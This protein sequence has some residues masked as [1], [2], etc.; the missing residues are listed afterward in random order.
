MTRYP[1]ARLDPAAR[2]GLLLAGMGGPDGPE[3]VAPFLANLFRD[4][5]VLPLPA[6]LARALG[7]LLVRLRARRVRR[8]Y[9]EIGGGSPQLAWT[10]RQGAYLE[11]RLGERGLDVTAAPAMRYWH[12]LAAAAVAEAVAAGAEQFLVLP[13]YPQWSGATSGTAIAAVLAGLAAQAP[14]RPVHVVPEWHRLGGYVEALARR[15]A[16]PLVRWRQEDRPARECALLWTAH[17]LPE[18]LVRAGDPYLD[19]TRATVAAAHARVAALAGAGGWWAELAGGPA[20]LLAF[21]SKVGPVRWIGPPLDR[22]TSALAAAGRRRLALVPV[23]FTCEHIETLHELDRELAAEAKAAG[24][25]EL[26][27]AEALNLDQI[28]LDSLAALLADAFAPA[29]AAEPAS[30]PSG[31]RPEERT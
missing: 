21:Q 19:Q 14:G 17:S 27:R 12:P 3:A 15:A 28:W 22:Q 8:R 16:A 1:R 5:A 9:E 4:P 6:P 11:R 20:P 2:T 24:V 13:M 31:P 26:A 7:A 18:R 25:Q 23:S 10:R 30:R 29:G